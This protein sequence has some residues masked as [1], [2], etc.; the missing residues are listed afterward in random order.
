MWTTAVGSDGIW[1][2]NQAHRICPGFSLILSWVTSMG[3]T[4]CGEGPKFLTEGWGAG[5]TVPASPQRLAHSQQFSLAKDLL[6]K[7][8]NLKS[9]RRA[10]RNCEITPSNA[11]LF[12]GITA[13]FCQLDTNLGRGS[14]S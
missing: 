14:L 7:L 5:A 10:F 4:L 11:H 6:P 8:L 1:L 12:L 2:C 13:D 9:P 3:E